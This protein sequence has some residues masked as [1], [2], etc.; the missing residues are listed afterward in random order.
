MTNIESIHRSTGKTLFDMVNTIKGIY[1]DGVIK[2]LEELRIKDNTEVLIIFSDEDKK[3]KSA[4]ALA[5]GSWKEIDT[6]ILKKHIY[7]DRKISLR[8]EAKF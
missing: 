6:E 8:T 5:A 3:K 1:K 7:E 2:P 4:F